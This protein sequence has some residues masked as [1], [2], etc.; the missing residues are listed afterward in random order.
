[1]KNNKEDYNRYIIIRYFNENNVVSFDYGKPCTL[2]DSIEFWKQELKNIKNNIINLYIHIPFCVSRCKY[3]Y[4]VSKVANSNNEINKYIENL[5]YEMQEYK[6]TFSEIKFKSIWVGGGTP[7]I[8]TESQ[9]KSLFKSIYKNFNFINS[10]QIN[11]EI[12][13]L[14]INDNKIK[15][16]KN[17]KVNRVT[18]GIQSTDNCVLKKN[19][20]TQE[21]DIVKKAIH[22]LK[23]NNI[24]CI[25]TDLM[26]G[27]EGQ[28]INSF[29][30]TV[31]NVI[32]LEP[33]IIHLFSFIDTPT[34]EFTKSGNKMSLEDFKK[35]K[36]MKKI[37]KEILNKEGY[38][39]E[40]Y[41]EGFVKGIKSIN[42]ADHDFYRFNASILG[43]G[44]G[45]RSHIF[46]S[47]VL[48]HHKYDINNNDFYKTKYSYLNL[49]SRDEIN[50]YILN[51]IKY[52]VN[53]KSFQDLFNCD[54]NKVLKKEIK[55]LKEDKVININKN[56]IKLSKNSHPLIAATY[57]FNDK[58]IKI[59][60][61]TI[62]MNYDK[63]KDYRKI[64]HNYIKIRII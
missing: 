35:I 10:P 9:L 37:G 34:T 32:K 11:I 60:Q 28:T 31:K 43:I 40:K 25:N 48:I 56:E 50:R 29:E 30:D 59:M 7:S 5:I 64:L 1:M 52:G 49:S 27:I 62:K 53:Y 42:L 38:E 20:R 55:N 61:D 33:N 47:K 36:K 15:I 19:N 4:C 18:L 39:N 45:A 46:C 44:E 8:L 23:K 3:C 22:S 26:C 13:P 51:N 12:S 58:E 57:L 16:L 54:L 2:K 24:E 63:E 41:E 17:Y 14:T 6:K 21:F